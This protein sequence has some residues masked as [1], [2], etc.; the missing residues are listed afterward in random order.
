MSQAQVSP[1]NA[2]EHVCL[3]SQVTNP[4]EC[5]TIHRDVKELRE[6]YKELIKTLT[7]LEKSLA[8]NT[9]KSAVISSLVTTIMCGILVGVGT[10]VFSFLGV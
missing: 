9:T 4:Y 2:R 5:H 8:I 6:D 1:S 7:A 3:F 10:K